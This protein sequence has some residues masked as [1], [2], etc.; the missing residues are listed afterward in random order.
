MEQYDRLKVAH[1]ASW[2]ERSAYA[3]CSQENV[4]RENPNGHYPRS[5]LSANSYLLADSGTQN[6]CYNEKKVMGAKSKLVKEI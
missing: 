4:K 6:P 5:C 2:W 3:K 1:N